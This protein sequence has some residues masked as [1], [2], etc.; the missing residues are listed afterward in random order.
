MSGV[1]KAVSD[2]VDISRTVLSSVETHGPD[3]ANALT[4]ILFPTG[5][6]PSFTVPELL[7]ALHGALTR[8]GDDIARADV[9]HATELADDAGPRLARDEAQAT[10]REQ[11]IGARG[12]LSS[13]YGARILS[14]YGLAG[15][16]PEDADLLIQRATTVAGLLET[17]PI[18][19]QPRQMGVSVDAPAIAKA[20]RQTID[21]LR[22]AL[23]DVRREEREAQLTLAR[24]NDAV[25]TWSERYQGVA[26][27]LTGIY[28]LVGRH[29]L[30]DVVRPTARRRAGMTEEA[31]GA[32][33]AADPAK[34]AADPAKPTEKV[35]PA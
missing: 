31:D 33:P 14:A 21:T 20:L 7:D 22:G 18:T 34:P 10:L 27:I 23:A 24:R 25:A 6:P 19:E 3:V 5:A 8:A 28:E 12:T 13:V 17:R 9:G 2:R 30:A 11:L 15:E 29:E 26:D 35:Q 32:K 4:A 16:T 1:T